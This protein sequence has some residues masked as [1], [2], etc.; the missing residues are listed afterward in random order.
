MLVFIITWN[1]FFFAVTVTY[2]SASTLP[3]FMSKFMTQQGFFWGKMSAAATVI[4][5]IP[6]IMG[7]CAQ[8]TLVKG[9]TTGSVK[10]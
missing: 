9:L 7:F 8:K 10:A 4:V 1:E 5:I 3:F 6:V 2:T